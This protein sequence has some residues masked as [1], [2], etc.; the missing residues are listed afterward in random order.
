MGALLSLPLLALPSASTV[1]APPS[2]PS[3]SPTDIKVAHH[4]RDIVLRRSNLLGSM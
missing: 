4:P 3:N 2:P 1:R